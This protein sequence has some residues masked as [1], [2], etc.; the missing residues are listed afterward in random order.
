[1]KTVQSSPGVEAWSGTAYSDRWRAGLESSVA[2]GLWR[3]DS[4]TAYGGSRFPFKQSGVAELAY[5]S[6]LNQGSI[7]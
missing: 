2:L 4:A 1:M 3:F 6:A 5:I 7:P